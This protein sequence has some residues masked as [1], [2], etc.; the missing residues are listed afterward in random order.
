MRSVTAVRHVVFFCLFTACGLSEM[1]SLHDVETDFR[2]NYRQVQKKALPA[3]PDLDDVPDLLTSD[4]LA[5]H[6]ERYTRQPQRRLRET[7][8]NPR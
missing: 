1:S 8:D 2:Q 4:L 5:S 3:I 7:D 6:E